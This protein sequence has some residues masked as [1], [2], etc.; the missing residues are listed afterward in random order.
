MGFEPLAVYS[1]HNHITT[2]PVNQSENDFLGIVFT[3]IYTCIKFFCLL[4]M[5]L[6]SKLLLLS[7]YMHVIR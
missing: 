2:Q 3:N 7:Y 6:H 4:N 5:I 1:Y